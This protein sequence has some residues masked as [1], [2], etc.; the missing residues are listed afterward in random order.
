VSV[1]QNYL[2]KLLTFAGCFAKMHPLQGGGNENRL[3]PGIHGRS[4]TK[5]WSPK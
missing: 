4:K 1:L 2:A 3:C 5:P